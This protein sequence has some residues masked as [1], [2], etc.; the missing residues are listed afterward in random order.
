MNFLGIGK[1]SK[2]MDMASKSSPGDK[3]GPHHVVPK[4]EIGDFC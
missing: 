1:G 2:L 4:E 3:V